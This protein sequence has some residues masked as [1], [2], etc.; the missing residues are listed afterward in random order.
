MARSTPPTQSIIADGLAPVMNA[1]NV[2]GDIAECGGGCFMTVLNGSGAPITV[3]V[4]T[5]DTFQGL[6]IAD[7]VITVAAGA[8]KDIPLPQYYRQPLDA[9]TG[10]GKAL[11]DFSAVASV[12]R[13]V[14]KLA[15]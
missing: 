6:A 11:V 13:A 9:V 7:R 12:T 8:S 10:P 3:T 1:P 4:Q 14:K 5:P 2:D 15:A